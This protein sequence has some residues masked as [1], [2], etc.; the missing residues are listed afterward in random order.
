MQETKA[1]LGKR[2]VIVFLALHLE[3]KHSGGE[4]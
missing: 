4:T 1:I 3:E 2:A